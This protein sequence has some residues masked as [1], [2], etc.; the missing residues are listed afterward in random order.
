MSH[1]TSDFSCSRPYS[2]SFINQIIQLN[3]FCGFNLLILSSKKNGNI[4]K[5]KCKSES[6]FSRKQLTADFYD[7]RNFSS[8]DKD[9]A[10]ELM[11]QFEKERITLFNERS[12]KIVELVPVSIDWI[13]RFTEFLEDWDEEKIFME[14]R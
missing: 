3:Y 7:L 5:V 1:W 9:N 2:F 11:I 6:T 14:N 12:E 4:Y 10:Y 8:P 13:R